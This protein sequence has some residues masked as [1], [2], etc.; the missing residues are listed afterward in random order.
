MHLGQ[1]KKMQ[2]G[3]EKMEKR[4]T[5]QLTMSCTYVMCSYRYVTVLMYQ[6][7]TINYVEDRG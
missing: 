4:Y 6:I 5:L 2:N 7:A 1:Q 3:G